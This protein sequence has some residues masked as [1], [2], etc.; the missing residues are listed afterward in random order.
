MACDNV[1]Y[2]KHEPESNKFSCCGNIRSHQRGE[3]SELQ[4]VPAVHSFP[5]EDTGQILKCRR[6]LLVNDRIAEWAACLGAYRVM[7]PNKYLVIA[8]GVL[9]IELLF[10]YK[11]GIFCLAFI[12]I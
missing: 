10:S 3:K 4:Y 5:S 7:V 9:S 8:L 1:L 12:N 11:L 2:E 6:P